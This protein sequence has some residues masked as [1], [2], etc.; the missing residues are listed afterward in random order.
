MEGLSDLYSAA[1]VDSEWCDNV[2]KQ[3]R[4]QYKGIKEEHVPSR[5]QH[6]FKVICFAAKCLVCSGRAE[7][8]D[9]DAL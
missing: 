6:A 2:V 7:G 9:I 5:T 3:L 4:I 1:L 8:V